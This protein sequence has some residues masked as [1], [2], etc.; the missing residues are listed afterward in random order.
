M[1]NPNRR[2]LPIA[3]LTCLAAVPFVLGANG[4]NRPDEEAVRQRISEMSPAERERLRANYQAYQ[5]LS[6]AERDKYRE[7]HRRIEASPNRKTLRTIIQ[8]YNLWLEDTLSASE[9]DD[10]WTRTDPLERAEEVRRI[11]ED[12]NKI[13]SDRKEL[14]RQRTLKL[15]V[16]AVGGS[17]R[18]EKM[19]GCRRAPDRETVAEL[20]R[21]IKESL[22][23]SPK[24]IS[25]LAELPNSHR[26]V[27]VLSDSLGRVDSSGQQGAG[28]WPDEELLSKMIEIMPYKSRS[29]RPSS[30]SK[31]R[32]IGMQRARFSFARLLLG[33]VVSEW[34]REVTANLPEEKSL[35][36]YASS[37]DKRQR[38]KL[39]ELLSDEKDRLLAVGLALK[40]DEQFTIG[41]SGVLQQIRKVYRL[42]SMRSRGRHEDRGR[43]GPGRKRVERDHP[44]ER[45]DH[46]KRRDESA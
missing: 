11:K 15:I 29:G 28:L 35:E 42:D 9:Y 18:L 32:P 1:K 36:R 26:Y 38:E 6:A 22:R 13:L 4:K 30:K 46:W 37:L 7:L 8:N 23:L 17:W 39:D 25:E 14:V 21:L 20:F 34:N 27:K 43:H 45:R 24:Q 10:L 3:V 41:L 5:S 2:L 12:Q 40:D 44:P 33:G 16:E 31:A 19:L